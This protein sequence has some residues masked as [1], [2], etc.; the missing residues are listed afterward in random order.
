MIKPC[1][2]QYPSVAPQCP[3]GESTNSLMRFPEALITY[4]RLLCSPVSATPHPFSFHHVLSLSSV[5]VSLTLS[6]SALNIFVPL[7][8]RVSL[9]SA[10][11]QSFGPRVK[12]LCKSL[13]LTCVH[14]QA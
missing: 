13:A 14:A 10:F 5:S 2:A 7:K 6:L 12:V 9:A 11:L 3:G 8:V 4:P 1:G